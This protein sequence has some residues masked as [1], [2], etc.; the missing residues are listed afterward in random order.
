MF[1]GLAIQPGFC[2]EQKKPELPVKP[3][4]VKP[5]ATEIQQFCTN[6]AAAAGEARLAWEA[7]RLT[8]L[9]AQIKQRI[10]ELDAKRAEYLE[11]LR[12]RDEA[13]KLAEDNVVAIYAKMRPEAAASQLS[14]M[15]DAMAAAVLT[16]LT[17]RNAGAIL[18]EMEPGR[19]ARLTNAMV[20]PVTSMNRKKS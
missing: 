5:R 8:E 13:M 9:E 4:E 15:D 14:A 18:N 7:E 19:A 11:W 16:K 17:S 3:V 6:N 20:G 10:A 12:K 2:V 1:M